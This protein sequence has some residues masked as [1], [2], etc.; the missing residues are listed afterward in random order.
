[1]ERTGYESEGKKPAGSPSD[2]RRGRAYG[3]EAFSATY[4]ELALDPGLGRG[5]VV[6]SFC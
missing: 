3:D 1:M 4:Q 6:E 5:R 2:Y